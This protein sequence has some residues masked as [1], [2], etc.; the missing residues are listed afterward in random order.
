MDAAEIM[1]KLFDG[2]CYDTNIRTTGINLI[3]NKY[4]N[5]ASSVDGQIEVYRVRIWLEGQ[6]IIGVALRRLEKG[7]SN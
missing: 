1:S 2:F 3:Y 4:I 7:L 6:R 5:Q